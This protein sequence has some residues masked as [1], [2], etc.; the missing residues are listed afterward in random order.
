[1]GIS[2]NVSRA[3]H[4]HP[5]QTSVSGNAATATKL[6]TARTIGIS[7]GVTGSATSFDGSSNVSINVTAVDATKLVGLVGIDNLPQGALERCVVVTDDAARFALT[8]STVQQGDTVKVDSSQNI[9]YI[10]DDTK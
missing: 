8:T 2:A 7:G 5:V 1:M 9:F 4:V 10:K 6:A 3:D